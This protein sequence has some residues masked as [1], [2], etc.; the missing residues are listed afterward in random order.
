[1]L[2]ARAAD[3]AI[4]FG[5]FE[6]AVEWLDEGRSMLWGQML[7]LRSSLNSLRSLYPDLAE[8]F[9]AAG[10][11]LEESADIDEMPSRP[12]TTQPYSRLDISDISEL[13]ALRIAEWNTILNDIRAIPQFCTYLMP[14]SYSELKEISYKGPVFI[15]NLAITH[16]DALIIPS[17]H[18]SIIHI[19]LPGMTFSRASHLKKRLSKALRISGR[20]VRERH[21]EHADGNGILCSILAELW[22]TIAEPIL[23]R[24]GLAVSYH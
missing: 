11:A 13:K 7:D 24:L 4:R 6:Q 22:R 3:C 9:E 15:I 20:Q 18:E 2:P 23:G 10:R 8:R 16:S 21:R 5:L 14:R 12:G 19:V 17:P 1:M